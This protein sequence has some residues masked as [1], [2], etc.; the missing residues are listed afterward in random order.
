MFNIGEDSAIGILFASK[1]IVQLIVNPFSGAIID[2]LGYDRPMMFGLT[3]LFL[4]TAMFA[5]GRSYEVLFFARSLQGVG[6][7]FADTS[8]FAMIA[9]RFTEPDQREKALGIALSFVS[10]GCLAAPP[11]G[12]FLYEFF[13]KQLPFIVLSL[14]CLLDGFLVI[15]IMAPVKR[16]SKSRSSSANYT[17]TK[18]NHQQ[19][20]NGSGQLNANIRQHSLTISTNEKPQGTPIYVLLRDKVRNNCRSNHN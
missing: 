11:F 6:S 7:A 5:V 17:A 12:G 18:L 16:Q 15:L 8:G 9:D 4:S 13:G 14:I 2:R 1:A 20:V 19:S 10:F 3:I